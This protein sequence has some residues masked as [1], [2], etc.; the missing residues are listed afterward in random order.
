MNASVPCTFLPLP[1]SLS[2]PGGHRQADHL[3]VNVQQPVGLRDKA[4]CAMSGDLYGIKK[5][6]PQLISSCQR[7]FTDVE[8]VQEARQL[9]AGSPHVQ[10]AT[11]RPSFYRGGKPG[12]G[13]G[14]TCA[15]NHKC[16]PC[17]KPFPS[18]RRSLLFTSFLR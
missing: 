6:Q 15:L 3:L 12:A 14:R 1:H 8:L 4:R 10:Q 13:W 16:R 7:D 11:D 9:G 18:Y 5:S 2:H 17:S